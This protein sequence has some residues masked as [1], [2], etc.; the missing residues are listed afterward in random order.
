MSGIFK[1][2]APAAG[3]APVGGAVAGGDASGTRTSGSL[4]SGTPTSGTAGGL[5]GAGCFAEF[6][7]AGGRATSG[8][9]LGNRAGSGF[10]FSM[11]G[12][13]GDG[14]SMT[15]VSR[16]G[17]ELGRSGIAWVTGFAGFVSMTTMRCGGAVSTFAGD[18]R[19]RRSTVTNVN[20]YSPSAGALKSNAVCD[21][22]AA[23][24]NTHR[25]LGP[26][27]N[28]RTS[29]ISALVRSSRLMG[30]RREAFRVMIGWT[31]WAC[32]PPTPIA[33]PVTALQTQRRRMRC[34]TVL[35]P[36][37]P[38]RRRRASTS[39]PTYLDPIRTAIAFRTSRPVGRSV[40]FTTSLYAPGGT[41]G[42]ASRN[43]R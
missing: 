35:P 22:G 14:G 33:S 16:G 2:D 15:F 31:D 5:G 30:S 1:S 17:S 18:V 10:P 37:G 23:W 36:F 26:R 41:F 7:P 42:T 28:S 8:S 32:A 38:A 3:G 19:P 25:P 12:R 20:Q 34:L 43:A 6:M 11:P 13:T 27:T 21:G 24:A 9:T 29:A 40:V 4:R 39:D